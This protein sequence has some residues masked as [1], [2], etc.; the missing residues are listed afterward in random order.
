MPSTPE[1]SHRSGRCEAQRATPLARCVQNRRLKRHGKAVVGDDQG[2]QGVR[3]TRDAAVE[4]YFIFRRMSRVSEV[5]PR[6]CGSFVERFA[7]YNFSFFVG[8]ADVVD[9][10]FRLALSFSPF[11]ERC[12]AGCAFSGRRKRSRFPALSRGRGDALRGSV[13]RHLI[14][15]RAA[16]RPIN[17]NNFPDCDSRHGISGNRCL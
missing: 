16:C 8:C 11:R 15:A 1:A 13:G 10:S 6:T 7:R 14:F 5:S 3:L 12:C 9:C 4:K 2:L 17:W